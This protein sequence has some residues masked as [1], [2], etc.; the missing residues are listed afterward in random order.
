ML[1]RCKHCQ[2]NRVFPARLDETDRSNDYQ[3]LAAG[4]GTGEAA[5][6]RIAS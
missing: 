4:A 6:V 5:P 3:D 1:G 2:L